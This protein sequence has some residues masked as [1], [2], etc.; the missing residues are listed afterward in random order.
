MATLTTTGPVSIVALQR[1]SDDDFFEFCQRNR[2]VRIERTA[3]GEIIVMPPAGWETG[4]RNS[5]IT[6][7]LWDWSEEDDRGR[8]CD[9]STGYTLPN[10]AVRSP[11]S[12]WISNKR[13][14][15]KAET[16]FQKFPHVCP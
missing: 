9:S 15:S 14:E 13:I 8:T 3:E 5:G 4:S 16:E 2:D 10:G 12:S 1:L 6:A 7:Q 11:D